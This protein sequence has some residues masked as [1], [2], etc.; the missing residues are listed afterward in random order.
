[1]KNIYRI[2]AN[3]K[4]GD[5]VTKITRKIK[6][7]S[8]ATAAFILGSKATAAGY[9]LSNIKTTHILKAC[10]NEGCNNEGNFNLA[11]YKEHWICRKC[12]ANAS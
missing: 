7:D 12:Y 3:A 9:S 5:K 6:A 8:E 10:Q 2:T 1:M 4:K 11:G